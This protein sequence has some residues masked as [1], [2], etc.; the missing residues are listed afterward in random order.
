MSIQPIHHS[1]WAQRTPLTQRYPALTGEHETDVLIIGAG[2]TGLSLA[3]E[4]ISRGGLRVTV[5]EAGVVGAGTTGASSGHLDAHPE[6]GARELLRRLG[7]DDARSYISRRLRAIDKIT[8]RCGNATKMVGVPAYQYAEFQHPKFVKTGDADKLADLR[9]ECS[10]CQQLGLP[11]SWQDKVPFPRAAGGFQIAGLARIDSLRYAVELAQQVVAGGATIFEQTQV[12]G[13]GELHPESLAAGEGSVR[14][15]HVVCATHSNITNSMRLYL[16]TPAYQSYCLVAR[17]KEPPPDALYWDSAE[18]Y[19]YTRRVGEL[20]DNLILV[21]GCDHRTGAGDELQAQSDLERWVRER[22]EVESMVSQWSAEL[23]EPTDGLPLIGRVAA[24]KN[25][26]IAT[27]LSGVGLTLGT[28]AAELIA[29]ELLGGESSKL[30]ERLSPSRFGLSNV[31]RFLSEQT[32]SAGNFAERVLPADKVDPSTL[33]PGQGMVGKLDGEFVAICR[34]KQGCEHRVD[35]ICAHM[36]G[37]VHWNEVE[38]TWDCPVHG[39]RYQAN[40]ERIY[41]PPNSALPNKAGKQTS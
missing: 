23:F 10:V 33:Q 5:C 17:V 27:G 12:E 19:H 4:I 3:L 13:P 35:P 14:F 26:W 22:F 11:T 9:E 34:D 32:T 29:D 37:V 41:G 24:K 28:M 36:G 7:P 39:G 31:G 25:V 40:G 6:M 15:K 30:A 20:A 1:Y 2:I 8:Q 16:E 18:P 38:Q 21:G